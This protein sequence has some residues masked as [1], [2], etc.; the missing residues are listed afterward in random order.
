MNQ[1]DRDFERVPLVSTPIPSIN[2]FAYSSHF[3]LVEPRAFRLSQHLSPG[4]RCVKA[5]QVYRTLDLTS[6]FYFS[7]SRNLCFIFADFTSYLWRRKERKPHMIY[8]DGPIQCYKTLA[9]T[10]LF[11][12]AFSRYFH[13]S[14]ANPTP[15]LCCKDVR[16]PVSSYQA[17][18]AHH[19]SSC[20]NRGFNNLFAFCLFSFIPFQLCQH[21]S[22]PV[23]Q[24]RAQPRVIIPSRT[25]PPVQLA[26]PHDVTVET[27]PAKARYRLGFTVLGF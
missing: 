2:G 9:S 21:R 13:F 17:G 16:N 15:Y 26:L 10:T 8:R 3:V 25:H 24:E 6:L 11:L 20:T 19:P 18:P 14:F 7:V 12:S 27:V 1:R 4:R 5:H 23:S 22:L